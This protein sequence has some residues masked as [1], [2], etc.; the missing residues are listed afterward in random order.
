LFYFLPSLGKSNSYHRDRFV[1][2]FISNLPSVTKQPHGNCCY[3]I[4]LYLFPSS[5]HPQA[6]FLSYSFS[7]SLKT[8]TEYPSCLSVTILLICV[9]FLPPI[10]PPLWLIPYT[11]DSV[12]P[13]IMPIHFSLNTKKNTPKCQ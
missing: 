11:V 13:E 8:N 1:R 9:L 3:V 12:P 10:S 4:L 2:L 5:W 6:S 7:S